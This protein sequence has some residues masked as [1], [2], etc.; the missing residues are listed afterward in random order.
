MELIMDF[1]WSSEQLAIYNEIRSFAKRELNDNILE[2]DNEGKFSWEGWKK[3]AETGILGLPIPKEYGGAG[4]DI[5]TTIFTMEALGYGCRDNGLVHSINSHLW[6]CVIPIL[7]FG[8]DKQKQTYLP[9]LSKGELVGGHAVTEPDAGSDVF[10][11]KSSA[12]K[13]GNYY[14]INGSKSIVSNAP[15]ADIIIVFAATAPDKGFLGGVSAFI[16]S[17]KAVGL[18]VGKPLEKMGLNT[19]PISELFFD[20]CKIPVSSILGSAGS[21]TRIFQETMEWERSCLF[22]CHIGATQRILETC[23]RYAKDRKQFGQSIGKFQS[24]S[25]KI[26][27]IKMNLE[28][29][30]LILYKLG[31]LKEQNK[32]IMLETSIAKLF[33]SENLKSAAM[34]AVQIHGFYGYMKEMGIEKELRDAIPAT[35]YSGTSEIQHNI[36]AR[37][38]GL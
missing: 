11:L 6:G 1:D 36:I 35:I 2:R 32:N 20:D 10:S 5:L 28:L 13:K 14:I 27:R 4:A 30:K 24:I 7:K 17:K 19:S 26:A 8:T 9:D 33:I 18:K 15:I 37:C 34:D 12:I 31:W 3:C 29:G 22:A 25:N 23:V 38:L 21:A 16:V